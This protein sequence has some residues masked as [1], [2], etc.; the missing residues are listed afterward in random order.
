[1]PKL[2]GKRIGQRDLASHNR[3]VLGPTGYDF[4]RFIKNQDWLVEESG[5]IIGQGKTLQQALSQTV[6][7]GLRLKSYSIVTPNGVRMSIVSILVY[8]SMPRDS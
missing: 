8:N 1:M 5:R 6:I 7:D 4:G 3:K 2:H